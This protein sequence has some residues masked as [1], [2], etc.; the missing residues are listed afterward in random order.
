[1]N[2][3]ISKLFNEIIESENPV[4]APIKTLAEKYAKRYKAHLEAPAVEKTSHVEITPLKRNLE[5]EINAL[6]MAKRIQ[7]SKKN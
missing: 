7:A 2:E 1:M 4:Y 5:N 6:E 3:N